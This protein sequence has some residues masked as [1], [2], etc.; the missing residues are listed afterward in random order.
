MLNKTLL[1]GMKEIQ[2]LYSFKK[3]KFKQKNKEKAKAKSKSLTY[4]KYWSLL[5]LQWTGRHLRKT[6]GP[7]KIQKI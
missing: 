2:I 5:G 6:C 1:A 4:N 3:Q 7:K